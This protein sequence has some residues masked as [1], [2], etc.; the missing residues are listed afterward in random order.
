ML[1]KKRRENGDDEH[2]DFPSHS[3]RFMSLGFFGYLPLFYPIIKPA[4]AL[5]CRHLFPT[6]VPT[7]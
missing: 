1:R 6:T 4:N 5:T 3:S 7:R 2:G